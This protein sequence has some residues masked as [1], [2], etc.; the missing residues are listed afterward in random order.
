M[1][2]KLD[3]GPLDDR[4]NG[5]AQP[6]MM[7]LLIWHNCMRTTVMDTLMAVPYTNQPM[8]SPIRFVEGQK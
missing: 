2:D 4:H 6:M 5:V 7:V 3:L 8:N 1:Q